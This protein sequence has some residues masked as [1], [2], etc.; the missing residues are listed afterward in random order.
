[1]ENMK[2]A[3]AYYKKAISGFK[4]AKDGKDG[5]KLQDACAKAWLAVISATEVFFIKNR[6]AESM[7]PKT[8]RGRNYCLRKY[9]DKSM[10]KEYSYLRDR[11]H[12]EGY[13]EGTLDFDEMPEYLD[14]IKEYIK[15]IEKL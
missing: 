8:D 3:K 6:V 14:D 12:I 1:M 15:S 2:K 10:R 9:A 7:L 4:R 11:V 5:V 13:Y